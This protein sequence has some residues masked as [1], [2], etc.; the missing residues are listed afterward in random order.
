MTDEFMSEDFLLHNKTARTLYHEYA[1]KMPI[2]D[3]HCH[4]PADKIASDHRFDN[5]TQI[6][7]TNNYY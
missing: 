7:F 6:F 3:Y 1:A 4:L 5:L 2:Y